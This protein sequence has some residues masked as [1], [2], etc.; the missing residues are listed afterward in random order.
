MLLPLSTAELSKL[1]VA[2]ARMPDPSAAPSPTPRRLE[3]RLSPETCAEMVEKYRAGATTPALCAEYGLSKGGLL[4]LLTDR[5]VK[6]RRQPLAPEQVE[7][8]VTLY[9]YGFSIAA[10][11]SYLDTSYNNVRQNMERLGIERRPRGGSRPATD[12]DRIRTLDEQ[13][14]MTA[15]LLYVTGNTLEN[16]AAAV[17]ASTSAVRKHFADAGM[18]IRPR[19]RPP[20]RPS[21]HGV[22]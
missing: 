15:V 10:I 14:A 18:P 19:G 1:A 8:A 13:Q 5:G 20:H 3:R 11:A 7:Q 4:R 22:A 21:H 9:S 2:A 12:R 6:M 17:G 16:V